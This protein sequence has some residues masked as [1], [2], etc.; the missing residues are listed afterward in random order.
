MTPASFAAVIPALGALWILDIPGRLGLVIITEQYLAVILGLAVLAGVLARPLPGL[1]RWP[2][3]GVGVLAMAGWFWLGWNYEG[4]L[5]TA[6]SRGPEKWVPALFA[7]AGLVEVTRRTCGPVLAVLG[8]AFMAYGF[9]GWMA[10]GILEGAYL[11]PARY[12][13]YIY[14]DSN[15]IPG[16][17][18]NVGANQ[19]LGFI[20]FG[21]TL[22]AVGGSDAMTRLA[23]SLM[24]H[25]RGGPAKVAILASSLFGTLS[26]STVANVMSTGVVTIPMMK[27]A[28]FPARYAGAIEA[29]ASNGGQ[30]APPVMGATA[31][32]IAEF[33]QVGYSDVVIAAFLPALFYYYLLYRQVDRYAAAHGILG[34]PR[35]TLPK[36][37]AALK[38]AW[39]LLA[40]LGVLIWFLFVLGYSPGKSALY[41]AGAALALHMVAAPRGAPRLSLIPR[42]LLDSG[43]T[44]I[45]ILLVCG[46]AGIVIGTINVTGLGFALTQALGKIAALGGLFAL[47][48]ATALLAIVLGVGMPTTGVYV[49]ISVLLAPALIRAG[50]GQM[51]A[52]LF[53]FYFGLL[54]M[55][56]P[57][58]AIASYAAASIAKSDMWA[59]GTTGL[60]LAI[61]AYLLPFV[62]AVNPALVMEGSMLEIA[63]SI[64]SILVA[65][66]LLSEVLA[67][68]RAYGGGIRRLAA[69]LVALGAGGITAVLPPASPVAIG[70]VLAVV[71][72]AYLFTRFCAAP[73]AAPSDPEKEL[74]HD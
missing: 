2:D 26:G 18:L 44:L 52:H 50:V 28:G 11:K 23:L 57:P 13:L 56:T 63:V 53:I 59:T 16:L 25:R 12:L 73:D 8:L 36:V 46:I 30:I 37:G 1:W 38:G 68:R 51:S 48:L 69:G 64:L 55:L 21:A 15:G 31:F 42:I 49:I 3:L 39:P 32:V 6:A 62:F 17:V 74:A 61:T 14:N 66:Y 22:N 35:D 27:K 5:M 60:K 9:L 24:G 70:L 54:S 72:I 71:L 45:P 33:L 34:E 7:I 29:V 41:S 58:V 19:I 4:W 43:Q 67:T 65:G 20:L 40:P 10:P 47:L